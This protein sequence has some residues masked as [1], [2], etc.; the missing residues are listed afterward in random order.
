MGDGRELVNKAK[1]QGSEGA[2]W[3]KDA[4]G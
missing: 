4:T 1:G 3:M 2:T